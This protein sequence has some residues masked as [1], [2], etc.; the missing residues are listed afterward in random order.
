MMLSTA[1]NKL[2]TQP[3]FS[4][5]AKVA[6]VIVLL[7]ISASTFSQG[8][9]LCYEDQSYPPYTNTQK[10]AEHSGILIDII[11]QPPQAQSQ[12]THLMKLGRQTDHWLN[13]FN[14]RQSIEHS[15]G[16]NDEQ[17]QGKFKQLE[18]HLAEQS[19]DQLFDKIE[20]LLKE[21][22]ASGKITGAAKSKITQYLDKLVQLKQQ[23]KSIVPTD[24]RS[25]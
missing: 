10:T 2:K 3:Y 6:P 4:V 7:L 24:N 25:Q 5:W 11:R 18:Q 19:A 13:L 8:Y 1:T 22:Q 16:D 23:S 15:A 17:S 20:S 21:Q 12:F 9:T 14:H